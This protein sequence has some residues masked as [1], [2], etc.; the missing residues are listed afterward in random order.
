MKY[1]NWYGLSESSFHWNSLE[2]VY[3]VLDERYVTLESSW[4]FTMRKVIDL[5]KEFSRFSNPKRI[6]E[7]PV[8]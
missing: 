4:A 1:L 7:N 3:D 8:Q 6:N 5:R 2:N